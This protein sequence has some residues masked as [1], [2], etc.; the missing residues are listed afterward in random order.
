[1]LGFIIK[2]L[3]GNYFYHTTKSKLYNYTSKHD[4]MLNYQGTDNLIIT[5]IYLDILK[6]LRFFQ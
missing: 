1:M 5:C 6:V 3:T 4:Q 2:L